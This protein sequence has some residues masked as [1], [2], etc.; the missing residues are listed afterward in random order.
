MFVQ[1]LNELDNKV[2]AATMH[3]ISSYVGGPGA[4]ILTTQDKIQALKDRLRVLESAAGHSAGPSVSGDAITHL[5]EIVDRLANHKLQDLK[6][7]IEL[8]K[9]RASD[10][11]GHCEEDQFNQGQYTFRSTTDLV[12]W[13]EEKNIPTFGL[14]WDLFSVLIM[15]GP[16]RHSGKEMADVNYSSQRT[17]MTNFE[18]NLAAA[19]THELP[20]CLFGKP[21]G[22]ISQP[23]DG[24]G[25]VSSFNEWM[26]E[27]GN[28]PY[29]D[30][31]QRR[32]EDF[33]DGLTGAYTEL[34]ES[35]LAGLLVNNIRNQFTRLIGFIESFYCDL[36]HRA[37]FPAKSAWILVGRCVAAVFQAQHGARGR[38]SRL[39]QFNDILTRG[40]FAWAVLQC[41]IIMDRFIRLNFQGHPLIVKE[42]SLFMLTDR[43]DPAGFKIQQLKLKSVEDTLQQLSTQ[44]T[45][46]KRAV[47]N[48]ANTQKQRKQASKTGPGG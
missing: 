26:G 37:H 41:H 21:S 11:E 35:A 39:V 25:G 18:N 46:L 47:D 16:R 32:L 28:E 8:L 12:R 1:R 42:L 20:H 19:M 5:Q 7:E 22:D 13:L 6:E 4:G 29:R 48:A 38:V 3:S 33:L 17:N 31:L 30:L 10:L 44:V 27:D 2:N 34:P 45:S 36:V 15:M 9:G 24:F 23:K 43:V 14:Y 40:M